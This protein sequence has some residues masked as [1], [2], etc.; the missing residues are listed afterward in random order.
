M[1][2]QEK[3]HDVVNFSVLICLVLI[4]FKSAGSVIATNWSWWWVFSPIWIYLS[5][6]VLFYISAALYKFSKDFE[7][8]QGRIDENALNLDKRL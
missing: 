8:P 1:T 3:K 2:L 6:N 7:E 5:L 4:V